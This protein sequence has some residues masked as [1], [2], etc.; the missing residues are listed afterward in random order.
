MA[1]P[2]A[3]MYSDNPKMNTAPLPK[4]DEWGF[5]VRPGYAAGGAVALDMMG[6]A[7]PPPTVADELVLKSAREVRAQQLRRQQA[8]DAAKKRGGA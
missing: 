6:V 4:L 1:K 2:R 8:V 7:P 3:T 5:P